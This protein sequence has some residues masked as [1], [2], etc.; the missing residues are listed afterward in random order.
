MTQEKSV[1]IV[2]D[3]PERAKRLA[4]SITTILP[5]HSIAGDQPV[6]AILPIVAVIDVD[7]REGVAASWTA[8]LSVMRV[9]CLVL[10]DSPADI[11]NRRSPALRVVPVDTPRPAILSLVF[12]LI[13]VGLVLPARCDGETVTVEGKAHRACSAV[14]DMFHAAQSDRPISVEE[15][16]AGTDVILEA[17]SEVGIRA[18]LDVI[19]RYDEQLYQHSLSVAGF[20]AAFGFSL[21]LPRS[22]QKRLAKAALLHDIGKSKIPRAILNK[23]GSLTASEM[24]IMRTHAGAGADLLAREHGF[25]SAMLDVVRYHH[26]MLDGSGYP[27]GLAGDAIPDLVRLVTI[28]DIHSAL[29]ERRAYREPL[30]HAEAHAIMLG[31]AGKLDMALLAAFLPIV[32][33]STH[34]DVAV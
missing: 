5:C 31:M 34:G 22:D 8:R 29:T 26:E 11:L 28:C 32:R 10:T 18:W 3:Q 24:A 25:D 16:E 19:G 27:A 13:D 2:S 33:Q 14:A 17:V 9:P 23:P 20:A 1:L 21:K 7:A 12:S 15:A 4:R 6:P 30:P